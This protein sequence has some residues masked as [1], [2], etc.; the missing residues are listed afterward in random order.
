MKD[1]PFMIQKYEIIKKMK[2]ILA[3][4]FTV[5]LLASCNH[6]RNHPGWAY[7]ADFDMYYPLPYESYSE[8]P[9]L[10]N[11]MTM[12]PPVEGTVSRE[13]LPYPY[14]EGYEGQ[15][16]AAAALHNPLKITKQELQEGKRLYNVYCAVCHGESGRGDG[17]LYS[18]GLF[19]AK[20]SN[21]HD[22][23]QKS[24][25]EG[26]IFHIITRGSL[27][28]LMPSHASQIKP[29]DRWRIVAYIKDKFQK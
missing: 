21:F 12:Q 16:Q 8:N 18:A 22:P 15:Q 10:K 5:V 20:P 28:K 9:V 29:D 26:E 27:S 11:H 7:M 13:M 3:L 23:I 2:K 4:I 6:D 14:P 24:K 1:K 25:T 17:Y 19:P